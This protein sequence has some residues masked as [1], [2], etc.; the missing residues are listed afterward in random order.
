MNERTVLYQAR[1]A[2]YSLLR[3][4]YTAAPDRQLL[5]WLAEERPFADFPVLLSGGNVEADLQAVDD[6]CQNAIENTLFEDF[7]QLYVGSGDMLVPPWE[8]VYRSEERDLFDVHTFQV[9]E[10][11]ARHGMEFVD[12]NKTPEDSIAIELEFMQL[13]GDRVLTAL[14]KADPKAERILAEDQLKFLDQH[15]LAW[16]PEF[17]S[18]SRQHAQTPFYRG[19]AGVLLGF[20]EWDRE[21][22]QEL[23]GLLP[24]DLELDVCPDQA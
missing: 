4:L 7:Y 5:D 21:T 18:L 3:R 16:V 13:L 11:Y 2:V 10:S 9:R 20:L 8:S 23:L 22:L 1:Q 15:M 19:L 24:E 17:V 12:K 6:A 14:E